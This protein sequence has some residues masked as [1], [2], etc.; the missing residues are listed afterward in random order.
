E[1]NGCG[2]FP[3]YLSAMPKQE[4]LMTFL[5]ALSFLVLAVQGETSDIR[6]S[7]LGG[8]IRSEQSGPI[9]GAKV[10]I[11]TATPRKGVG[12]LCPSCYADCRKAAVTDGEGK[13]IFKELDP[14][15]LFRLL[16][17]A[18]GYVPAQ[19]TNAIDPGAS[20]VEFTLKP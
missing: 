17:V 8:T 9:A 15:L 18:E 7:T 5:C 14:E 1:A 2:S 12:V 20:V 3:P 11:R 19:S 16:V 10:F 13:F 6:S 4:L